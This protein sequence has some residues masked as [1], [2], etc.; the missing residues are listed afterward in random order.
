MAL[1]SHLLDGFD[2]GSDVVV[3]VALAIRGVVAGVDENFWLGRES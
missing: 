2:A 1:G 3:D